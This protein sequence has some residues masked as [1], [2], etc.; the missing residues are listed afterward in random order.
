MEI[1]RYV[2]SI[3][4]VCVSMWTCFGV[5]NGALML[6]VVEDGACAWQATGTC[7]LPSMWTDA[8]WQTI[9]QRTVYWMDRQLFVK[10]GFGWLNIWIIRIRI[11]LKHQYGY[12][13]SYLILIWMS[14]GC[15]RIR[16]RELFSIRFHIRIRG[17]SDHISIRPYP[18]RKSD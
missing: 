17:I 3:I 2:L 11:H 1:H 14:N 4:L 9:G 15:I 18:Q 7:W 13:Y 5:I 12:P 6:D 8:C 10:D 16:L